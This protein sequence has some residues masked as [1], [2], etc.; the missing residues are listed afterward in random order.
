MA[1]QDDV[2]YLP[3]PETQHP[4]VGPDG[5]HVRPYKKLVMVVF[6]TTNW[7]MPTATFGAA[8][9]SEY[10]RDNVSLFLY[11]IERA[12]KVRLP[13][14]L[15]TLYDD[16]LAATGIFEEK[17]KRLW[18]PV[19]ADRYEEFAAGVAASLDTAEEP[20]PKR[21]K[22]KTR[23]PPQAEAF[24]QYVS[25]K[26]INSEKKLVDVIMRK[27]ICQKEYEVPKLNFD[28]L[29]RTDNDFGGDDDVAVDDGDTF[30]D[31]LFSAE[32]SMADDQ[33]QE[34]LKEIRATEYQRNI[35]NY[36]KV[37]GNTHTFVVDPE[38]LYADFPF[39]MR[40]ISPQDGFIRG[41][42]DLLRNFLQQSMEPPMAKV[43]DKLC[44]LAKI[45]GFTNNRRKYN[46]LSD[47]ATRQLFIGT[48]GT[49]PTLSDFAHTAAINALSPF[50]KAQG[51]T[52]TERAEVQL[53]PLAFAEKK[54]YSERRARIVD[55]V[56]AGQLGPEE[57]V[58]MN[59]EFC[60]TV[61]EHLDEDCPGVPSMYHR[62]WKESTDI[63]DTLFNGTSKVA[64]MAR[65]MHYFESSSHTTDM[66]IPFVDRMLCS[67]VDIVVTH[68]NATP[69]QLRI[70]MKC[71][72]YMF[73]LLRN[74][75][76]PQMG[77]CLQGTSDVGKSECVKIAMAMFASCLQHSE[78]DAS[79]KAW[80]VDDQVA[81][82]FKWLDELN[83][84]H[85][86]E[87]SKSRDAKPWQSAM[88][89]GFAKYSQYKL[90]HDGGSDT[91]LQ[92]MRDCRYFAVATMNNQMNAALRSRFTME[93][94]YQEAKNHS[95]RKKGEK[96]TLDPSSV[97]KQASSLA[98]QKFT[99]SMVKFWPVE[100]YGGLNMIDT[101]MFE[102]FCAMVST[103]LTPF[104]I[105][106][107]MCRDMD[108]LRSM[109]TGVMVCRVMAMIEKCEHMQDF[110]QDPE[111][112]V[113]HVQIQGGVVSMKDLVLSLSLSKPTN[114]TSKM[115]QLLRIAL[116]RMIVF[117]PPNGGPTRPQTDD[118]SRYYATNIPKKNAAHALTQCILRMQLDANEDMMA[119]ALTL[120]EQT[121]MQN[122]QSIVYKSTPQGR[123]MLHV[124]KAVVTSVI[125]DN[126]SAMIQWLKVL[127][128]APRGAT[129]NTSFDE[130][131][132]TFKGA[133]KR[134]IQGVAHAQPA[135][136]A[137]VAQLCE[138]M[139]GTQRDIAFYWLEQMPFDNEG[140][141]V[142]EFS[143]DS[144]DMMHGMALADE[145]SQLSEECDAAGKYAGKHK[146]KVVMPNA[147]RVP[148]KFL[149]EFDPD[150]DKQNS[151]HDK[152]MHEFIDACMAVSGEELP[153][154][155]I[156]IGVSSVINETTPA[157]LM[158]TVKEFNE[159]VTVLNPRR[160]DA[161]SILNHEALMEI[162]KFLPENQHRL[163][164]NK[165][166]NLYEQMREEQCL[167]NTG[168]SYTD[169]YAETYGDLD[170]PV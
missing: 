18:I 59:Q 61:I 32:K 103:M 91:L 150:I 15:E 83:M 40:M 62:L 110:A 106:R 109:A 11:L 63:N 139:D 20:K 152:R 125:T 42:A 147:F 162:D 93:E 41:D 30:Y 114:A 124:L 28:M 75:F 135:I 27:W 132:C 87:G 163:T 8:H 24:N 138:T 56:L 7:T 2:F 89:T 141:K 17:A 49:N 48:D 26:R 58:R 4:P 81:M 169:A 70:I 111:K 166:S 73:S 85:E 51:Y 52:F 136:S 5:V 46:R 54:R 101:R 57:V 170:L 86:K 82:Q 167:A 78:N 31:S 145:S 104:G 96:A 33:S 84:G 12:H 158:Y 115:D 117:E 9:S 21:Q 142:L 134:C 65:K 107:M 153:G 34:F 146:T 6:P 155:T 127:S 16:V 74:H 168:M 97:P 95:G 80:V 121:T 25:H 98:L 100:A 99:S 112:F 37:H 149:E 45:A 72:F 120:L 130:R 154:T 133:L 102:V 131:S 88:S 157:A 119:T 126:E 123:E 44:E 14:Y 38:K 22:K 10:A 1:D 71:M 105:A 161:S 19:P 164:F 3:L 39:T 116:K 122:S 137:P 90:G 35:N 148:F 160:Y 60:E 43:R 129:W 23:P 77:L 55:R 76:G 13:V 66:T 92:I 165:D 53:Y 128:E 67:I 29:D 79:D 108:K 50:S 118:T 143:S 144:T 156:I 159:D 94:T 151:V 36:V 69:Q 47:D 68:Q 113:S 64:A 140:A